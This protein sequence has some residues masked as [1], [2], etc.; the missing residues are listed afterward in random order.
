MIAVSPQSFI[1]PVNRVRYRDPRWFKEI[2]STYRDGFRK[3]RL[4]DLQDLPVL[5]Q[6]VIYF[7]S[8]HRLDTVHAERMAAE[9]VVSV[10]VAGASGHR[11]IGEMR[12]TGELT[13]ILRRS[14]SDG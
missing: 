8:S 10:G 4:W 3:A 6:T 14:F 13:T 1:D 12:E 2:L 7:S 5:P 11:L 9:N